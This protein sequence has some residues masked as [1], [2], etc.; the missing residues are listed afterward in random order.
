MLRVNDA[1]QR[2][3]QTSPPFRL[4]TGL[5]IALVLLALGLMYLHLW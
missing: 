4:A 2:R 1:T 5:V 3:P